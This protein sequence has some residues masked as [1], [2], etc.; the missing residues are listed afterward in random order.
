[1]LAIACLCKKTSTESSGK[2][3]GTMK[4]LDVLIL[5]LKQLRYKRM[6]Q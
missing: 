6:N 1:M 5:I 2:L 3:T 4:R